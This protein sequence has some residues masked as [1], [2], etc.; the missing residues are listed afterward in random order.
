MAVFTGKQILRA[1]FTNN[2]KDTIEVVYNHNEAGQ[3]P[4]YISVWLPATDPKNA[5]LIGLKEEGWTF[6][7]IQAASVEYYESTNNVRKQ[8]FEK[9]VGEQYIRELKA[10]VSQ[11]YEERYAELANSELN[12]LQTL[13]TNNTN[14][15]VLFKTKLAMFEIPQ[16]KE[17]KDRALKQEIRTAKSLLQLFGLLDDIMKSSTNEQST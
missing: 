16:V 1:I 11:Q 17:L 7:K 15:D 12:I 10:S 9:F 4:E 2:Q 3:E 5:E 8:M 14:E 6:D 13:L